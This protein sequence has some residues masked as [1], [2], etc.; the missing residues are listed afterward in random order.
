MFEFAK[1]FR[2]EGID[3]THNPEFTLLEF[4][5]AFADY[6]DMMKHF[7]NIYAAACTAANGSPKFTYQGKEFDLTPPWP[8]MTVKEAM[9]QV[10][11]PGR[12]RPE[13]RCSSRPSWTRTR[14]N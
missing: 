4:Y 1:D 6:N 14:S 7:E 2:N 11:R 3:R 5:Q 12:G 10:R 8:R 9:P 13:R